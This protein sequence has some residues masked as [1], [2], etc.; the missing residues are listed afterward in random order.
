[1]EKNNVLL[2]LKIY[3]SITV[4]QFLYKLN[5]MKLHW[6][7]LHEIIC[8]CLYEYFLKNYELNW[9]KSNKTVSITFKTRF[10]ILDLSPSM[11]KYL[12]LSYS[13]ILFLSFENKDEL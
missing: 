2:M 8:L 3:W 1:M 6:L 9:E 13:V 10:T 12:G 7:K 5:A 11:R 4:N